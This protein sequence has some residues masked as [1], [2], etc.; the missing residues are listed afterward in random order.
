VLNPDR[1]TP[2]Q[3]RT[4]GPTAS[5]PSWKAWRRLAVAGIATS[6]ARIKAI[7]PWCPTPSLG[8]LAESRYL[9]ATTAI[10]KARWWR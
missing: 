5:S 3:L 1:P 10:P 9:Q 8:L 4:Y 2:Q 7:V 6:G